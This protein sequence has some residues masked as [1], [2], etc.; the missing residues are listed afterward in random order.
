M[1][2][3]S[4]PAAARLAGKRALIYG[5]GTGLGLACAEA[6]M[7]AGAAAFI[8]G[9]R[10]D[11]L[12]EARQRLAPL[13][14]IGLAEGDFTDEGDVARVTE[15]AVAFMG[16]LDTLVVSSGRSSIG[17]ALD[18]TTADFRAVMETNLLGP[19]LAV[20]TAAP[21]LVAGAPASIILIASI[22]AEVA[23]R[24]R[25]AYCTSKAGVLGMTRAMALDFADKGVRV[26]AISPSLVLTDLARSIM[27]KEKDPAA[28]LKR[29]EAQ[30]PLGRLGR[31]EDI[32][33]AAVY[34]AAEESSWTTGQ[35]LVLD[36]GMT[37]I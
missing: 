3:P 26:N 5:G 33:A 10:R 23:M 14:R 24:E 22:V 29:R 2:D 28:T 12:E 20:R 15:Q 13:G 6:L 34:L 17:S 16:G 19:F 32:G 7:A 21:H 9:R 1:P 35:N 27:A 37:I 11:K 31:P 30:H 18:A 8:T 25:V 36:G 4:T